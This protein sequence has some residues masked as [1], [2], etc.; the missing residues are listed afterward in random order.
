M[1]LNRHE[2]AGQ[3]AAV[4]QGV[5]RRDPGAQQRAGF[6]RVECRWNRREGFHR[7]NH[8]LWYPPS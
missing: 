8:E 6:R 2:V 7:R 1:P 5:E 4:T 3:G